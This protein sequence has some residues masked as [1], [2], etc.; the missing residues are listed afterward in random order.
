MMFHQLSHIHTVNL[1][2][3]WCHKIVEFQNSSD[4]I[5]HIT[6]SPESEL[7]P[8]A[9]ISVT[10]TDVQKFTGVQSMASAKDNG[11]QTVQ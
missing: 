4:L 6:I 3:A 1:K 5:G 9:G 10:I 7:K 8:L 11:P 2:I